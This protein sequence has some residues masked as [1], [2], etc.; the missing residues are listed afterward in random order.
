MYCITKRWLIHCITKRLVSVLQGL[1]VSHTCRLTNL[2]SF[3]SFCEV[4][5]V[6]MC[7]CEKINVMTGAQ[8]DM[9]DSNSAWLSHYL[10]VIFDRKCVSGRSI[11]SPCVIW[12]I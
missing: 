7:T 3:K 1:H 6:K 9:V 4:V 11:I 2:C 5:N 10:V 12:P 8:G